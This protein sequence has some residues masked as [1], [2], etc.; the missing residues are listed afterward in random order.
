MCAANR[1]PVA[2]TADPTKAATMHD[3]ICRPVVRAQ[4]KHIRP[5]TI[6]HF[7]SLTL[8]G[9]KSGVPTGTS[10]PRDYRFPLS[11]TQRGT[12][13]TR[14]QRILYG[15]VTDNTRGATLESRPDSPDCGIQQN[16]EG[17]GVEVLDHAPGGAG[18]C[19]SP[20]STSIQPPF[21][22][23]SIPLLHTPW[24]TAN[25]SYL[26]PRPGSQ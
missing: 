26:V 18:P 8:G 4:P 10:Q 5:P 22:T 20:Y 13:S 25:P 19:P 16:S 2:G 1:A 12:S 7:L 23:Q 11:D 15:T 21:A 6:Q 14:G 24:T 9:A 3:T 17:G